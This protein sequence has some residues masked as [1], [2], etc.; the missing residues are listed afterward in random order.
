MLRYKCSI[1]QK[2]KDISGH[3]KCIFRDGS[4]EMRIPSPQLIGLVFGRD[5]DYSWLINNFGCPRPGL[6]NAH[7]PALTA[8]HLLNVFTEGGRLFPG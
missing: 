4:A 8:L 7:N 1:Q 2:L 5:L 3:I 6:N